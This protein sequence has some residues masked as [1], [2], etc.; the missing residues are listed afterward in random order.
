MVK[1][2]ML[3]GLYVSK[4]LKKRLYVILRCVC[5]THVHENSKYFDL[6]A[7]D[8]RYLMETNQNN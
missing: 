8:K 5:W 3:T 6:M 1:Y 4:T 7:L 2:C